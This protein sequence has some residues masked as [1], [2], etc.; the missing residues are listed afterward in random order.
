MA[1][2]FTMPKLGHLMEEGVILNWKRK[3]GETIEKGDILLE[4]EIDKG[5]MDVESNLSGTVKEILVEEGQTVPVNTP[6][7]I[8]DN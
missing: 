3:V 2:E 8:I 6:L 4:I 1:T 5:A 7:A